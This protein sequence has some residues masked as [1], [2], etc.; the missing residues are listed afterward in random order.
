MTHGQGHHRH[1]TP[2]YGLPEG[3]GGTDLNRSAGHDL[4]VADR[5]CPDRSARA[6]SGEASLSGAEPD[7]DRAVRRLWDA[8]ALPNPPQGALRPQQ[9]PPAVPTFSQALRARI[10]ALICR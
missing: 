3:H 6:E 5:I 7:G 1:L 8:A 4:G 10:K 9:T 2:L